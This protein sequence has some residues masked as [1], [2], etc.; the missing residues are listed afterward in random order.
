MG[1]FP[2][3][4]DFRE[5]SLSMGEGEKLLCQDRL[6]KTLD[7]HSSITRLTP[8]H[9]E[10]IG[11]GPEEEENEFTSNQARKREELAGEFEQHGIIPRDSKMKNRSSE[12]ALFSDLGSNSVV[13]TCPVMS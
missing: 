6:N 2:S 8:S 1:S 3:G 11:S 13:L 7:S 4:V 5:L 10:T 12:P 9:T